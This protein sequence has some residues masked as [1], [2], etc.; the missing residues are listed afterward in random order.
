MTRARTIAEE[1]GAGEVRGRRYPHRNT[2]SAL[3][4]YARPESEVYWSPK[5]VDLFSFDESYLRRLQ[6][7]DSVTETHFAAYFGDLLR[8]KLR[9]R[10]FSS[11][12]VEDVEQETFSRVITAVRAGEIRQ[13]ERLGAFVNSVCNNVRLELYR[14]FTRN[15]HLDADSVNVPDPNADLEEKVLRQ[16]RVEMVRQVLGKLPVRDRNILSAVL[17]ERDKDE[18]CQEFGVDRGY[19][20]VLLHRA[21]KSFK[22]NYKKKKN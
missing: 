16:E 12:A 2:E 9:S 6:E 7:C 14:D 10:F 13:P 18:I 20:R 15:Q 21:K 19:L 3:R 8:I 17:D 1:E 11:H 4:R 5:T 22:T